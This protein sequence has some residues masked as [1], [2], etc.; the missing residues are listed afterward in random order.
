MSRSRSFSTFS[1]SFFAACSRFFL[2][3]AAAVFFSVRVRR[4]GQP[5]AAAAQHEQRNLGQAREHHEHE[6]D[7]GDD[8]RLGLGEKLTDHFIAEICLLLLRVTIRPARQR[9]D[10][11]GNLADQPVADGQLGVELQAV[12]EPPVLLDHADIQAAEDVD[13]RDD[14]AGDGV[15]ADEFAGT[16]HGP[17]KVGFLGDVL[18]ALAGL[19]LGDDAGVQVGVDRHLLAGHGVQREPRGHFR[20]AAGTLGDHDELNDEDDDEDDD[21]DRQRAAVTKSLKVCT[22]SPAACSAEVGSPEAV[23]IS[24]VVATFST[25]RKS[26]TASSSD[27]KTANS[28]GLFT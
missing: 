2:A 10:E 5:A 12:H 28:S 13:E 20:D 27:G 24:R 11:G 22:T 4:P 25:S 8:Q 3:A 21:A 19:R 23:R 7:R 17:V 6:K 15:A 14:D 18:A 16:V 26:V 1:G 9:D